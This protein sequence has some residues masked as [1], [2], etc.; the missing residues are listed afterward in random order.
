MVVQSRTE[1]TSLNFQADDA[2]E[3][4]KVL[5]VQKNSLEALKVLKNNLEVLNVLQSNCDMFVVVIVS[6]FMARHWTAGPTTTRD[7]SMWRG[8]AS[9]PDEIT[10]A[11]WEQRGMRRLELRSPQDTEEAIE[12]VWHEGVSFGAHSRYSDMFREFE[13]GGASGS[14]G[15][16]DDE[17]GGNDEDGEDE[18]DDGE[19]IPDEASPAEIPQ[20]H[21]AGE[22]FPQRHVAWERVRMSPG[23]TSNVVVIRENGKE[24]LLISNTKPEK[25]SSKHLSHQ[26]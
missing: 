5:K 1:L 4:E 25:S 12:C 17:E 14:G 23:K 18:D 21:V 26:Q 19:R 13:S 15:R 16:D 3:L 11:E 2:Y 6:A 9:S 24:K 7:L 20:R 8:Q 10:A 22:N